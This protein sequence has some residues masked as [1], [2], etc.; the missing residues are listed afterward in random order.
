[1]PCLSVHHSFPEQFPMQKLI[2]PQTLKGFRD[3]LPSA[4]LARERLIETAR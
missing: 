3:Y 4:M 2:K 1:M